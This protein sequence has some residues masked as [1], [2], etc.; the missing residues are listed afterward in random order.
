[1]K[2]DVKILK[3][4]GA[5]VKIF[6]NEAGRTEVELETDGRLVGASYVNKGM[7]DK[8]HADFVPKPE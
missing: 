7:A 1:M 3:H 4:R 6:E 8:W 5:E 2:K